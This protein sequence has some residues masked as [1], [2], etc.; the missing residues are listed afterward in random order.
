MKVNAAV[1]AARARL[2]AAGVADPRREASELYAAVVCGA[3]SAA[4]VDADRPIAGPVADRLTL[5]TE[6]RA[7]G[8]PQAYA[9]GRVNFRG[10]WLMVDHRVLIP[11]AETEGLVQHV[12]DWVARRPGGEPPVVADIGTGSGAIAIALALEAP[13]AGIIAVDLSADALN[14]AL[15][16]AQAL[17]V[18]ERIAFRRGDLLGGL[19]DDHVDAVVSNPPYVATDELAV[20]DPSV[21]DF[22]PR[23]ALDGGAD[24]LG[25]LR[26]L[27][28][29]SRAA[30]APGGLL[31]FE[32]DA[33][34]ADASA[35]LAI[36]AGF[37]GARV[38]PDLSGC[39]RYVL[40]DG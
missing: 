12:L 37:A 35:E 27:L 21:K 4:F 23:L 30:L 7:A 8:W 5:A 20:L 38:L 1:A 22:E 24:G 15:E 17:G 29:E 28:A 33:G 31:A 18:K 16:N 19:L 11:R 13:V 34:R 9:A 39:P 14:V 40:A 25:L 3:L 26:R 36:A 32:V 2:A 10:H 6:R